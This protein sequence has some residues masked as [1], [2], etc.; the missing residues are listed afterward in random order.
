MKLATNLDSG[1]RLRLVPTE[2]NQLMES[3]VHV[4]VE[5]VLEDVDIELGPEEVG[6]GEV[7]KEPQIDDELDGSPEEVVT[8]DPELDGPSAK[9]VKSD[10]AS[11]PVKLWTNRIVKKL[12]EYWREGKGARRRQTRRAGQRWLVVGTRQSQ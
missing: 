4:N 3:V 2:T 7:G 8:E 5:D 12:K 6:M 11:V 9:A 1:K 10:D